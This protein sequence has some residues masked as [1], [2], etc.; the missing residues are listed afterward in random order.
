MLIHLKQ[1]NNKCNIDKNYNMILK[2]VVLLLIKYYHIVWNIILVFNMMIK[3]MEIK[4]IKDKMDKMMRKKI[5]NQKNKNLKE[6]IKHLML[7]N[8]K[9]NLNVKINELV[10]Y[11]MI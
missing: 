2:L 8:H 1:L 4:M 9:K 10:I 11:Q 6:K 3:D 5:K 7:L